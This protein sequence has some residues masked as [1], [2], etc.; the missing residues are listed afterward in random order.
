MGALMDEDA[1]SLNVHTR[2]NFQQLMVLQTIL[3]DLR[4]NIE[5]GFMAMLESHETWS[6]S[7]KD[8]V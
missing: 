4:K 2:Y 5:T 7:M 8:N 1:V 6:G 3:I